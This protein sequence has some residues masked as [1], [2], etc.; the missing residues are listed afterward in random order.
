MGISVMNEW[1][2]NQLFLRRRRFHFTLFVNLVGRVNVE[3]NV[4]LDCYNRFLN[5]ISFFPV[6]CSF[7]T[8]K[9]AFESREKA[10]IQAIKKELQSLGLL[11]RKFNRYDYELKGKTVIEYKAECFLAICNRIYN[12]NLTIDQFASPTILY[13]QYDYWARTSQEATTTTTTTE[14]PTIVEIVFEDA[15]IPEVPEEE[16]VEEE[17]VEEEIVEENL[18]PGDFDE[19]APIFFVGH[20]PSEEEETIIDTEEDGEDEEMEQGEVINLHEFMARRL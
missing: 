15:V 19:L 5:N 18:L 7:K 4:S 3:E 13:K 17:V 2:L 12:K 8:Y 6:S 20:D 11:N 16:V 1:I 9:D 14:A 10:K